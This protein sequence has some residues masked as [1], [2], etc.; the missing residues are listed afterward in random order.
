MLPDFPETKRLFSRF[1]RTYMRQKIREI[2]PYSTVQ[3][4]Y[5]HEGRTMTIIR[6]DQSESTS[7]MEELSTHLEINLDEVPNLTL[8]IVIDKLD[9]MIADLVRKQ[10]DFI[11]ERVSSE[12]PE[13]QTL[14]AKGR[15]FDAQVAIEMLEKMQIEFYPDGTPH[16]IFVD[17]PLFTAERM[18][19][20][21][22]EFKNNPELKR[23]FD[24]MLAKKKEEWCARETNRKL[25]G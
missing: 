23:K 9:A 21:E 20:V 22:K 12:I 3:T 25:V 7:G 6:A 11:R 2:S 1:F 16:T 5:L 17:G 19:A 4:R 24:E 8:Q 10:T 13:S 15:R 14:D 18:A